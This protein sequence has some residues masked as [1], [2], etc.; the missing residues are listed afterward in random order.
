VLE[1]RAVSK[2]RKDRLVLLVYQD[3]LD[4]EDLTAHK[5]LQELKDRQAREDNKASKDQ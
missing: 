2:E 1:D 3:R 4:L 5:V